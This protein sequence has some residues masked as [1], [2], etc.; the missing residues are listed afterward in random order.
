MASGSVGWSHGTHE[1]GSERGHVSLCY[2]GQEERG[3][4]LTNVLV[5]EKLPRATRH[6]SDVVEQASKRLLG[7]ACAGVDVWWWSVE[8]TA[9]EC[10][11]P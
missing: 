3:K 2:S 11:L 4:E 10:G 8:E 5:R 7:E 1:I 6:V 9:Q